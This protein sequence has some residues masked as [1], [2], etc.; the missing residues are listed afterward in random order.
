[1][2]K[3]RGLGF[4]SIVFFVCLFV[5][6]ASEQLSHEEYQ[7]VTKKEAKEAYLLPEGTIC[8]L[9]FIER[10]NPHH[11]SWTK[12]RRVVN[13][14]AGRIGADSITLLEGTG[15]GHQRILM[16]CVLFLS[17]NLS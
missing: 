11:S 7:C 15:T 1:M 13:A 2:W 16:P 9:K 14:A 10:D 5:S 6:F 8:V 4:V 3:N 17:G 12:V